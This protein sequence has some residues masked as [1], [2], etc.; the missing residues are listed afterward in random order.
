[1]NRATVKP[2]FDGPLRPGDAPPEP[3]EP[4]PRGAGRSP[5]VV[6]GVL[7]MLAFLAATNRWYGWEEGIRALEALDVETYATIASAA[8]GFPKAEIGSA[9][10]E[11]FAVPWVLGSAGEL[12]G[13]DPRLPFRAMFALFVVVTL[14]L[15]V[16]IC[17]RL[18]LGAPSTLLCVGLFALNPY[19][20]RAGAIAPGPVDEAFVTGTAILVWGLVAVRFGGV[21]TG[22]A[23][24]ILGRQTALLAVPAAAVWLYAGSGWRAQPRRRRL[25]AAAA[26][27]AAVLVLYGLIK[28]TIPSFTYT[29]APAIPGDTMIPVIGNPGSASSAATHL[30]RV[31]A[32]LAL[33]AGA[34]AGVLGGLAWAGERLRPP[35]EFWCALGIGASIVVQPLVISPHFPGF[36]A[37]EQRLAA[38]GLF[39]LCV[40]LAYLLRDAS[41]RATPAWALGAG[42]AAMLA[43]SLHER[44]TVVGP[45]SDGQFAALE[46]LAAAVLGTTLALA[47]RARRG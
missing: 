23:V 47:I 6:A 14:G 40:A 2:L 13:V 8:P 18:G 34:I 26:P 45:Q 27:V 12:V 7:A 37:N 41:P 5:A 32:P 29:F 9:F 25:L 43:A 38:L 31:A 28:L 36:E 30:A 35:V 21:L 22:A 20:F 4:S 39:P 19:V 24:S 44:F 11:R 3:A 42:A 10:T 15:M 33:W 1:M 17:G 16:D 46:L